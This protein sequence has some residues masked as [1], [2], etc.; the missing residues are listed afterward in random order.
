MICA[1]HIDSSGRFALSKNIFVKSENFPLGLCLRERSCQLSRRVCQISIS[2][3]LLLLLWLVGACVARCIE[4]LIVLHITG[5]DR[6]LMQQ[7]EP[8]EWFQLTRQRKERQNKWKHLAP[9]IK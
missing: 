7:R 5:T 1:P 9:W 8:L 2:F 4:K 3:N 6:H